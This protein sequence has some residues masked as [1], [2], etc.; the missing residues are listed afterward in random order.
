[1]TTHFLLIRHAQT[2]WNVAGRWQGQM[3]VPLNE[4][5]VAQAGALARR[6]R[7]YP[8]TAVYSSDLRRAA[9]T[10]RVVGRALGVSVVLDVAWR[11]RHAGIFHSMTTAELAAH[12]PQA[13]QNGLLMHPPGGESHADVHQRVMCAYQNLL[14]RHAGEMIAIVSHGG[15]LRMLLGYVLGVPLESFAPFVLHGNTGLSRIEVRPDRPPFVSLLN[16]TAHLELS[17]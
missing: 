3:D 11:E 10:A 17:L 14:Q 4:T 9:Q 16:D 6:L 2:N 1:M 12:Y 13:R 7:D 5:G 8:I 15:T